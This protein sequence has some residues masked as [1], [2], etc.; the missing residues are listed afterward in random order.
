[1]GDFP[2]GP[3]VKMLLFDARGA[4]LSFLGWGAKIPQASWPKTKQKHVK[5]EQYDNK[6][7]KVFFG[8]HQEKKKGKFSTYLVQH[9]S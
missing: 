4:D 2:N 1:M 8:P 3:V 9:T 7:N 5:Q 6:L